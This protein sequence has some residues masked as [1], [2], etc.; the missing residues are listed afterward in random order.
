MSLP[1]FPR[2]LFGPASER[3]SVHSNSFLGSCFW[4]AQTPRLPSTSQLELAPRGRAITLPPAGWF[5]PKP[6]EHF[7]EL[8]FF[9]G[10]NLAETRRWEYCSRLV[11]DLPQGQALHGHV[12][13]SN[14][15]HFYLTYSGRRGWR[16]LRG[17]HPSL[18][19]HWT[20]NENVK[21]DAFPF[22]GV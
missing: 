20:C 8:S 19:W 4:G 11:C 18:N 3:S 1:Q 6:S 21:L 15:T 9:Q 17:I 16:L 12:T 5:T 10:K 13:A 14:Y 2:I 7:A 22:S